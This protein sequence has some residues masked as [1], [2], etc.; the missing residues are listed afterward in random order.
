MIRPALPVDAGAIR[1]VHEAAFPTALEAGLVEQLEADGDVVLSYVA[2]ESGAVV[3]HVLL[4]RMTV[5]ADG[6]NWRGLGLAPIGVLPTSQGQ[7]IGGALIREALR[8]AA[9]SG[10]EIVFLLGEPD[11]YRRFGFATETA[12]PFASPYA[13]PYFMAHILSDASLPEAGRADYAVA[14]AGLE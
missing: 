6:R 12:A 11:Y 7:G 9:T 2:E 5:T 13:G 3:G 10:E 8:A 14:F 1:S 4:S